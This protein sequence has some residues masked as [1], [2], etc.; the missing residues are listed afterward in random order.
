MKTSSRFSVPRSEVLWGLGLLVACARAP[1]S[2]PPGAIPLGSP[3]ARPALLLDGT[4][5]PVHWDDGDTFATLDRRIRARLVGYNTLESYGPV[6]RWGEWTPTELMALAK[7][8]G[9]RAAEEAWTCTTEEG[10]GGYGR[11]AV[12]CPDLRR[13]LLAE[14]LAHAFAVDG[15]ADQADL[16]VQAEAIAARVGMWAKGAPEGI[17][18][19]AHSLD[20]REGATLTYDRVCSTQTGAAPKVPH[21]QVHGPCTEVCHQGSCLLYVPYAQRYGEGRAACLR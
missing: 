19:S 9:T 14:G 8:A 15:E 1:Q 4:L 20:E 2:P 17:V 7:A 6:H 21:S 12:D 10:G 16:V 5:I 3:E 13:A 11:V 18:T